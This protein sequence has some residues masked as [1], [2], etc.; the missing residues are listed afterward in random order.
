MGFC[1]GKN[2]LKIYPIIRLKLEELFY[3]GMKYLLKTIKFYRK[4]N[5]KRTN[6]LTKICM[7]LQVLKTDSTRFGIEFISFLQTS[8]GMV[9]HTSQI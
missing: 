7:K 8:S 5:A 4:A 6:P 1:F 9:L 3:L 2:F